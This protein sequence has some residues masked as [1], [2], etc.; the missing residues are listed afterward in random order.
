[1]PARLRRLNGTGQRLSRQQSQAQ[2]NRRESRVDPKRGS[3]GF[4]SPRCRPIGHTSAVIFLL[5]SI[6]IGGLII[7]AIGRLIV[8]GPQPMGL[9]MTALVGIGGAMLGALV[10]RGI[11][12]HP[13]NHKLGVFVLEVLGAAVIVAL[14]RGSRGRRRSF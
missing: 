7:G 9:F 2:E 1:M 10:S 3:C 13:E 5:L 11:W 8:P 4:S 12:P 14:I 6:L